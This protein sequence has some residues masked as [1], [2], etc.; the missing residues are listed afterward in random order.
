MA[1]LKP[2]DTAMELVKEA[3]IAEI[4]SDPREAA[5]AA[6]NRNGASIE[7]G[8]IALADCLADDKSRL[9][10][11]KLVFEMHGAIE[12]EKKN[13]VPSISINIVGADRTLIQM[14][15]PR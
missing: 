10:A 13:S 12:K 11:A 7:D 3:Q 9:N 2:F 4:P 8:A 5:K 14:V 15:T 1:T 6:L